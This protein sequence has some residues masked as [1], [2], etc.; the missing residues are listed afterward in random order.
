MSICFTTY[1]LGNGTAKIALDFLKRST[2]SIVGAV[3]VLK[4]TYQTL[5]SMG[6]AVSI[7]TVLV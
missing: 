1:R 5:S 4:L 6:M 3:A 2:F 7:Q